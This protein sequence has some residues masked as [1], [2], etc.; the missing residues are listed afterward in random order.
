MPYLD[1]Q[2]RPGISGMYESP[3]TPFPKPKEAPKNETPQPT[4][5]KDAQDV[6]AKWS[7]KGAVAFV[8]PETHIVKAGDNLSKIA[9]QYFDDP[10]LYMEI[11]KANKDQLKHPNANIHTGMELKLPADLFK[12][13]PAALD[14]I[15]EE[16]L[17]SYRAQN[18]LSYV[19]LS[20][21]EETL[22]NAPEPNVFSFNL[23][24]HFPE[25]EI[26]R[27]A[28]AYHLDTLPATSPLFEQ[29][30]PLNADTLR[31]LFTDDAVVSESSGSEVI[32]HMDAVKVGKV[33]NLHAGLGIKTLRTHLGPWSTKMADVLKEHN[34]SITLPNANGSEIKMGAAEFEQMA[35]RLE[36]GEYD[37]VK[38]FFREE[39]GIA[40]VNTLWAMD[41]VVD[42]L[43][44][45]PYY[46]SKKET[47]KTLDLA[48]VSDKFNLANDKLNY[49]AKTKSH[50][51]KQIP[52]ILEMQPE[53]LERHKSQASATEII[54]ELSQS[55]NAKGGLSKATDF[56]TKVYALLEDSSS[57]EKLVKYFNL[58]SK[59]NFDAF[60]PAV[61]S[62][63][64]M[65]ASQ[66]DYNSYFAV[67]AVILNRTLGRNIKK[68]A[69]HQAKHGNLD[70]FKPVTV[71]QIVY[72]KGQFEIVSRNMPGKD[73]NFY[74][75]N[76]RQH[77]Y[78][79][80]G[81]LKESGNSFKSI[82]IAHEVTNDLF[83]GMNRL[84]ADV[85]GQMVKGKGRSTAQLFYFNQSRSRDYNHAQ[86]DSAVELI[87]KNNTHVFF[88]EWGDRPY[89]L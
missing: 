10:N 29:S 83:S 84:Q 15:K 17:S 85:D 9:E 80:A 34:A 47:P 32:K 52:V 51:H 50:K 74:D 59:E 77:Q 12:H 45:D 24:E 36:A 54:S 8:P 37:Q 62:E 35:T 43:Q 41:D 57:R 76:K 68:A 1:P 63:G 88:K 39:L 89:F 67:G 78:F 30:G 81:K 13:E 72:E 71:K 70:N 33:F 6:S 53:Q 38:A 65:A 49:L 86:S 69:S 20:G 19:T 87:D 11:Y 61:T 64:G 3:S 79:E 4:P 26:K 28:V 48:A 31:S 55:F 16:G 60:I 25:Q 21:S 66:Q 56:E 58:D 73:Y 5:L 27:D 23:R 18:P 14:S 2:R 42:N 82:Q 75:Y 22:V 44:H 7:A 40:F 46:Q